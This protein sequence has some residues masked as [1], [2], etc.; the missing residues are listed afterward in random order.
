MTVNFPIALLEMF[1][2]VLPCSNQPKLSQKFYWF[3]CDRPLSAKFLIFTP[4]P[5]QLLEIAKTGVERAMLLQS[6]YA[7]ETDEVTATAWINQQLK[8]LGVTLT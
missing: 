2:L 8:A 7:N 5:A 3:I 6:S 4:P 1:L